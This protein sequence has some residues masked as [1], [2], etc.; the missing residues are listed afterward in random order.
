M[1]FQLLANAMSVDTLMA[2]GSI[3]IFGVLIYF[4][5][6][7]PEK[8][9]RKE[10]QKLRDSIQIGDEILTI[11]GLYGKIVS[12]KDDSF[13]IET[14]DHSK[15]RITKTAVQTNFTKHE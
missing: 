1:N 13:I 4:M 8:K 7:R 2:I 15:I 11:G 10:E 6:I 5:M 9:R 3:L 12:V 14:F